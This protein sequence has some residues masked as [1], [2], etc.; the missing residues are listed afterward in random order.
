M[1]TI[2]LTDELGLDANV[3][4]A[5]F[6]SL[7]KYFQQLPALRMSGADFS[8]AGGL[9]LDQPALRALSS[10]LSFDKGVPIGAGATAISILAGAN[11]S[12]ELILRTPA[13]VSL[14]DVYSGDIGI[15][16]GTCYVAFGVQASVGVSDAADAGLL[17]FGVAPGENFDI[18]NYQN[19]PL[20]QGI[21]LLGAVEQTVGNFIIPASAGDLTSLPDGCVATVTGTGSLRLSATA[22]LR[23]V[24]NPLASVELPAPLPALSVT[25]GGV[26]QV[27]ASFELRCTFQICAQKLAAGRV[28]LGWYRQGASEIDVSATV[29]EGLSAGFGGAD[30]F[31]TIIGVI[32]ASAAADLDELQKAGLPPDQ[33]KAIQDAAK[34]A[35][36][37]KLELALSTQIGA[38]QSSDAVFLYDI[39]AAALT[40]DSRQALDQALRGDL[41]GLHSGA[42]PGITSVQSVWEKAQKNGI[43]LEV[44]L[45]GILNAGS[46]STLTSSGAVLFEPA[47]GALVITDKTTAERIRSTAVNFGA[48]TQKLRHVMAESFLLT[49]VYQGSQQQ[50]G[51]PALSCSHDF[52]NLENGTSRD[53]MER[54]LRVGAALG[55][56][57]GEDAMPPAG[58]EDFGRTMIHARTDYDTGLAS[59]LFLDP[60]GATVPQPFYENMGR[61]AIQLLVSED[62]A[63]AFRRQPAIDDGLWGR[64]K[65]EGQPGLATLFPRVPAPL[66]AAVTADYTAI[67]WWADAMAGAGHRLAAMRK[68][69]SRHPAAA[70]D[71]PE[72]QSLRQDLAAHLKK[73][74]ATTSERFGEP[75]GL[76]AMDEASG[77]RAG[78]SIL[79]TG[80][81]FVSA[82]QRAPPA[83]AGS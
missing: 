6:S 31:S 12:L 21:T 56:Y 27:G 9:T 63:D 81:K 4:L 1:A 44:N 17:Q 2:Q 66:L 38:T 48:D 60:S 25:A 61:A 53:Q 3:N 80:P 22:N 29:S 77:R 10:G 52:F 55:L 42:L 7:L 54:E 15:A 36:D 35:V 33:V 43:Q 64:M 50:V 16:E 78:A 51:G 5:P 28:Q 23:A 30:L 57:S 18:R 24:T 39:D 20:Q 79:V 58:I 32:S 62:D 11:G 76:I 40:P 83:T 26:A 14:L 74:A 72:F 82:K 65:A 19:F 68:W 8:Q 59:A 13:V 46:I 37:R 41:S 67:M 34:A 70:L 73:V 71:D 75:W 47:T 45:L 49:A 69:F